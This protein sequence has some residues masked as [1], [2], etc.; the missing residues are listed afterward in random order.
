AKAC[1]QLQSS[2]ITGVHTWWDRP[3]LE[4]P[5]AAIVGRLCQWVFPKPDPIRTSTGAEKK[6]ASQADA[7]CTSAARSEHYYQIVISATANWRRGQAH[8]LVA[9][10]QRDLSEVF[11]AVRDAKLLRYQIVTDP[12]AVFSISPES[13]EWRP[14][15]R[16]TPRIMLAGDWTATGWPAT[17]EGAVLSGFR[18]AEEILRLNQ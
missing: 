1:G 5:H 6:S 11:P 7:R 17:M 9:Q 13:H 12:Q 14:E 2:A 3:W 18:A 10:I 8:D 4:L 15:P 16:V